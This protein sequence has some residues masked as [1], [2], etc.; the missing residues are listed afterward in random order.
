MD[1]LIKILLKLQDKAGFNE[2]WNTISVE[3]REEILQEMLDIINKK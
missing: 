2:W 3:T 1:K